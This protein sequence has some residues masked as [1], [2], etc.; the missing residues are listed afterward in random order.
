MKFTNVIRYQTGDDAATYLILLYHPVEK[1]CDGNKRLKSITK[2]CPRNIN[3]FRDAKT[4]NFQEKEN[5]IF[6]IFVQ[7]INCWYMLEPP[8]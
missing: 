5:D 1:F 7:Q 8:R 3:R 2:T 4:E 6:H